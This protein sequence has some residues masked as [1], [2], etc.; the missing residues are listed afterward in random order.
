MQYLLLIYSAESEDLMPG[1]DGWPE[2]M[3]EYGA[4]TKGI[5]ETGEFKGGEALKPAA[6]ATSVRIRNGERLL[7]D[8]P[9]AETRE[10]LGGFYLIEADTL[11]RAIEIAS[12]IPT[13]RFG[14][15]EVRPIASY[16]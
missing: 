7:T 8:G 9:F 4:F 14:T 2:Y 13:A 3:A 15:V 16:G 5:V 1:Q 11:D 6:T 10:T 12:K